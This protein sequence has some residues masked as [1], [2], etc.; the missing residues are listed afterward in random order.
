VLWH[1]SGDTVTW[2]YVQASGNIIAEDDSAPL[3]DVT[4]QS[5]TNNCEYVCLLDLQADTLALNDGDPVSTWPD[6]SGNGYD[7]TQSGSARPAYAADYNDHPSVFFNSPNNEPQWLLGQN[8]ATLDDMDS[9]S[10]FVVCS[11]DQNANNDIVI[12]KI[13]TI[14]TQ[15][16]DRGWC[17]MDTQPNII[18]HGTPDPDKISLGGI[19]TAHGGYD[20]I[21]H[22][23]TGEFISKTEAHVY[24]NG[25]NSTEHIDHYGVVTD[26]GNN[27]PVTIGVEYI[28]AMPVWFIYGYISAILMCVPAPSAADRAAIEA[29][30]ADRYG[31][32][33]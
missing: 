17:I 24:Y 7:F 29:R 15:Y 27:L 6:A 4:A 32:T 14:E 25:D 2:E 19:D 9:F 5:V 30:L 16:F 20:N 26:Y 22:V 33:L 11:T 8:W 23:F 3:G 1:G 28:D 18:E 31:V 12:A 10:V 13:K 21:E